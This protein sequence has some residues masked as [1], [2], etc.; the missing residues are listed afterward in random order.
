[1]ADLHLSSNIDHLVEFLLKFLID[2]LGLSKFLRCMSQSV[3]GVG[4]DEMNFC[5][6]T[7]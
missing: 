4:L 5:D 6:L 2:V 3:E 1:M 7:R